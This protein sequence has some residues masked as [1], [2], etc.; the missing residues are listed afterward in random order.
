MNKITRWEKKLTTDWG[1]LFVKHISETKDNNCNVSKF[2]RGVI[3]K[4]TTQV[5]KWPKG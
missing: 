4:I 3:R 1:K 2:L 5:F